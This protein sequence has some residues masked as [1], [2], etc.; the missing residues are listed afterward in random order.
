VGSFV[1]AIIIFMQKPSLCSVA[2]FVGTS[3]FLVAPFVLSSYLSEHL[4]LISIIF[5]LFGLLLTL[6][7]KKSIQKTLSNKLAFV[8]LICLLVLIPFS[9]T[10]LSSVTH[11]FWWLSYIAVFL[12][13][14]CLVFDK[15]LL[16]IGSKLFVA[17][18]AVYA[19]IMSYQ[20]ILSGL[21][22]YTR[23]VGLS[24]GHNIYGGFLIL[25]FF[26][27]IYL[28]IVEEERW[29]KI[30]WI[31]AG[32]I[33]FSNIILT[34]SRGT[35]LS[36]IIGIIVFAVI[37]REKFLW[38]DVLNSW[39]TYV[40]I[41]VLAGM[42]TGGQ[43]VMARNNTSKIDSRRLA[44]VEIFSNEDADSNAFTARLFY[45]KDALNTFIE[46]PI[47]GFGGGS[48]QFALRMNKQD[49]NYGSFAD[50][51]NWFLR[52]L[53]EN[54]ILATIIFI[55]FLFSLFWGIGK[56]ILRTEKTDKKTNWLNMVIFI[57]L[58][59]YLLHGLMDMDWNYPV[60]LLIF[61]S[62]AGALYGN[63]LS[64]S[65]VKESRR[66]YFSLWINV[67]LI[68][69]MIISAM[70]AVQMFRSDSARRDGDYFYFAKEDNDSAVVS[71]YDA[72]KLNPYNSAPWYSLWNVYMG[73]NKFNYA[74]TAI[75]KAISLFPTNGTYYGALATSYASSSNPQGYHDALVKSI[76][77]FPANN[78]INY[79]KLV[80]YDFVQKDYKEALEYLDRV[81]PIYT[82]YQT[83]LWYKNDPNSA[84]MTQNL[85]TLK[86]YKTKIEKITGKKLE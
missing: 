75:G 43:W 73:E 30:S 56:S 60:L 22:S 44:E 52:M 3:L 51:H 55:G 19:V 26:L 42:I 53:V 2:I 31:I 74:E 41:L 49:P 23:L 76:K 61:F 54:G 63:T 67:I 25:P 62:F 28:A 77:Y 18:T 35:W 14:Q 71:Y 83:V 1:G 86:E 82:H 72:I 79:V 34:F 21:S 57:G 40:S 11:L 70:I 9:I 48:Y 6:H 80:H 29:K 8:F 58:L 27:S 24:A 15:K 7:F 85:A 65:D 13:A 84:M 32:A 39:K 36:I 37:F 17:I 5:G 20:F 16:Q 38:H 78:L 50:P 33:I 81:I 12:S 10:K 66:K 68:F 4:I 47:F 45:F 59:S 64:E 46:R 69:V